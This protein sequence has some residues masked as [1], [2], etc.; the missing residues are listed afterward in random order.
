MLKSKDILVVTTSSLEGVK[1]LRYLKPIS[2]H[3]VA[4]TNLINDFFGGLSDVFGGRSKTYQKQ[5]SSLYNEAI[6]SL[7]N[8]AYES[9][10][11][12]ILGLKVDLDE[13]SGKNKSMFMITAIGTAVVIE[14]LSLINTVKVS[15]FGSDN[16]SLDSMLILKRKLS[17]IEQANNGTLSLDDDT[18]SFITINQIIDV[19]PFLIEKFESFIQYYDTAPEASKL[20][21]KNLLVYFDSQEDSVKSKTLYSIIRDTNNVKLVGFISNL[22]DELNL[23]NYDLCMELLNSDDFTV[24]KR[25]VL[26]SSFNKSSY[27]LKDKIDLEKLISF[28]ENNFPER[29]THSSKKQLLSSKEKDVW[30]CECSKVND[31]G[32]YCVG[33]K[34]DINGFKENEI[35][36]DKVIS[37]IQQKIELINKSLQIVNE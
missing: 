28:L 14:D 24:K 35:K 7:K 21:Y 2:A 6:D 11:N 3:V 5:L 16:V 19:Y 12:A 26:V 18:W 27:S 36:P 33:C 32:Q 1:V 25:G 8:T 30:I 31:I 13:I 22:I 4:G 10:A 15:D 37:L 17:L 29:G 20:F 34:Q 23:F 9:G